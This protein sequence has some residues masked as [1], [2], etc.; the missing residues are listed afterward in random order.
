MPPGKKIKVS[1]GFD[2]IEANA[3]DCNVGSIVILSVYKSDM[4][5]QTGHYRCAFLGVIQII[6]GPGNMMDPWFDQ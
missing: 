1:I 5:D 6:C 3:S 2:E 4:F